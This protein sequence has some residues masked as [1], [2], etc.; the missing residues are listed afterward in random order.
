MCDGTMAQ[1]FGPLNVIVSVSLKTVMNIRS[2]VF[3]LDGLFSKYICHETWR[4][5]CKGI[6][7]I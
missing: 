1:V 3:R 5:F 7:Q 6:V 4:K 2:F